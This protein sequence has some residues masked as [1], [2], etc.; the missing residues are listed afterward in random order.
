MRQARDAWLVLTT[1]CKG[2]LNVRSGY[3]KFWPDSAEDDSGS[4]G[5]WI[6]QPP[7]QKSPSEQ[8]RKLRAIT[9]DAS[10]LAWL[11]YEFDS[12]GNVSKSVWF[13]F[14]KPKK[15]TSLLAKMR[16]I[17]PA[18]EAKLEGGEMC[19]RANGESGNDF[20]WFRR[21]FEQALK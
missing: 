5:I 10:D 3:Q 7:E 8:H 1:V 2:I 18:P 12:Q 13:F 14:D 15:Q 19:V 20:N 6:K 9:R 16:P 21:V 17:F 4:F 11:G